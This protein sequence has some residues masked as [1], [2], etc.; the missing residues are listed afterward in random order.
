MA[1]LTRNTVVAVVEEVTPGTP[2]E[3]TN[4]NQYV[5]ISDDF[6]I[7][8]ETETLENNELSGSRGPSEP[9]TGEESPSGNFSLNLRHSGTEGTAP[10]AGVSSLYKAVYGEQ[11]VRSTEDNTVAASTT[12]LIK[13]DTGEGAGYKIGE[14][15]LVKHSA[16]PWE[17]AI[18]KSISGDDLSLL[19]ALQNAPGVGI[20]LGKN[21]SYRRVDSGNPSLSIWDY[22]SNGGAIQLV[23]G[24]KISSFTIDA[25]A[26]Q[27]MTSTFD[28]E[29]TGNFFNALNVS[30]TDTTID[31]TDDGGT[32]QATITAKVYRDP[33]ELASTLETAMNGQTAEAITVVYSNITGK[34]TIAATGTL[35]SILWS[36]GSGTANTIGDLIG[37]TVSSDDTGSTT[38]TSDNAIDLSSPQTA[39]FTDLDSLFKIADNEVFIGT[40]SENV[41]LNVKTLSYVLE[42][43]LTPDRSI[44]EETGKAGN[45]IVSSIA[46]VSSIMTLPQFDAGK[47]NALINNTSLGFQF[48]WGPRSGGNFIAGRCGAIHIKE[49]KV[50][51]NQLG[52]EDGLVVLQVD[53]SGFVDSNG[54]SE[55]ALNFV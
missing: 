17:I 20:D 6:E 21:I 12:I 15:L 25:E 47:F 34:H 54:N 43:P 1:E 9:V 11:N 13:V 8:L 19:F 22:R 5:P 49:S 41:C 39:A 46:T 7:T 40:Q 33:I 32:F 36:T 48:N 2:V 31:W 26:N 30:S 28:F 42:T 29:G 44:C 35:F 18:V 3:P 51:A 55:T 52:D 37:F 16:N 10:Q 27:I 45:E 53:L 14:A 23:P 50:T 4:A 24:T 38:Y